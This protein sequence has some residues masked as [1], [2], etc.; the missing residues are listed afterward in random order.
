MEGS[1]QTL[2]LNVC[3]IQIENYSSEKIVYLNE[4][5]HQICIWKEKEF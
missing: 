3:T 4:H 2:A 5:Q 1:D